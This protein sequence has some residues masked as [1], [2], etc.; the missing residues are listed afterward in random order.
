MRPAVLL[1]LPFIAACQG[2]DGFGLTEEGVDDGPLR[3]VAAEARASRV[4]LRLSDGTRCVGERP[5]GVQ[6]GWSGVTA[7][8]CGYGL[9]Y[10]VAFR[11]GGSPQRFTIEDPRGTLTEQGVPGPRAEVFVTDVDGTRKLF[12][13]PLG[14][15]TRLEAPSA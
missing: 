4:T 13:T 10:T 6:T 11:R 9:P 8:D 14:R 2:V 3:I 12:I 7:T 5:E 15:G 1:L